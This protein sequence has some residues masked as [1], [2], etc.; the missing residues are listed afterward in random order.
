MPRYAYDKLFVSALEPRY[1]D[2][3]DPR[4]LRSAVEYL[5][6][7]EQ[8]RFTQLTVEVSVRAGK[9]RLRA[10]AALKLH[11]IEG[12]T[13]AEVWAMFDAKVDEQIAYFAQR[14]AGF[15]P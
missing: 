3:R 13:P 10:P 15:V 9:Y 12:K 11:E 4:S 7:I 5:R 6:S 8:A 14:D 2:P 1:F